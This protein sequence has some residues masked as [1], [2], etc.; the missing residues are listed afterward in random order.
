MNEDI[1]TELTCTRCE[2]TKE[3]YS[4]IVYSQGVRVCIDCKKGNQKA[5]N[6]AFDSYM[7]SK[8]IRGFQ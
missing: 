8:I 7:N 1:K 2:T 3:T 6:R 4:E 5:D